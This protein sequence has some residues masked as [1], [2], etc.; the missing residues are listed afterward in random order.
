M[1]YSAPMR[2]LIVDDETDF[3][4]FAGAALSQEG[5]DVTA[6]TTLAEARRHSRVYRPDV[7]ILDRCLPDGDGVEFLRQLGE[8]E[9]ARDLAVMMVTA[10][11]NVENAVDALKLGAADYLV[12]PVALPELVRRLRRLQDERKAHRMAAARERRY[13]TADWVADSPQRRAIGQKLRAVA[14]SPATPVLI[15]G[16]SGSGKQVVAEVLHELTFGDSAPFVEVKCASLTPEA[17]RAQLFGAPADAQGRKCALGTAGRG[18]LFL[19]QFVALPP[20]LQGG[21]LKALDELRTRPPRG[22]AGAGRH[23]RVVAATSVNVGQAMANGQLR[24][25]LYHRLAVFL[26]PLGELRHGPE[27]IR[28]LAIKFIE[29]L[30][31]RLERPAPKLTRAALRKLE[32]HSFGGNV[33]ELRNLMERAVLLAQGDAIEPVHIVLPQLDGASAQKGF[34]SLPPPPQ[35][36]PLPLQQVERLY[37]KQVLQHFGGRRLQAAE[38]LGISYPTFLRRLR[39]LGMAAPEGKPAT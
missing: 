11:G 1:P 35:D 39:E 27:D 24:A 25:D 33:H 6:V 29:A 20:P 9:E 36:G 5:F 21:L 37:V 19:D 28:P 14:T 16:P 34:F 32:G 12:K 31:A 10:Y 38:S 23:I 4:G 7:V 17:L 15:T 22:P 8:E 18:T 13:G 2:V 26:L 3:C 30:A